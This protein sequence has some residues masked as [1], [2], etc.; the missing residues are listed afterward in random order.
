M[1]LI[2]IEFLLILCGLIPPNFFDLLFYIMYALLFVTSILGLGIFTAYTHGQSFGY[3]YTNLKLV[4]KNKRDVSGLFLILRQ[5]IGFGIPLMVIGYFFQVIGMIVW[6][7]I[8][9][10]C[11][12]ATPRQQTIA[13][14]LFKTM[15]VHEPPMSEKL[16]E[17]T[18]EFIDEPIK[19]VKQQPEPSPAISSDLVSPIDLHLRSNYSDDGYY[20][21]E[22]LFKQAY[23][24]HMEV[25]SIT[26]HNCARANAA[27]VRFAPMY[28]IQYIPGVEIDTQWKG[29][30]VRILGYYIDWT[31]DI[32]DE[33]E[34]ESL[35]REK[36]VSIERTQ[37]FEDF[38]GIHIDV[39]S[40]MQTSRFQTITAQ[41]ITKMVF[42]NK[43]VRE[44]SFVKKYLESSKNE[45]QARRRFARDVF[46][47]GGP[48]YV[49]ASYPALGDMV[50][51]IHDAGGIAILSSC[52]MDHIHD[53]EIEMLDLVT[54]HFEKVIVILNVGNIID[55]SWVKHYGDKIGAVMYVWQGGMESGNAVADL[56]CGNVNP[57]GRLTDT[58]ARNY[59]DYPSSAQFGNKKTNEYTE[60]IFVGYRYF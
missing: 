60:D 7:A 46:G 38:C 47:K 50:K 43:R 12:C 15:P 9:A 2:L 5:A 27:A 8:N 1:I 6:W 58:I 55:M 39:E 40:L 41:D 37:K 54:A 45:T 42:H 17:E 48:C 59:Y 3:V 34:R 23:Q 28:N 18:E 13:D 33:I 51:A 57:S 25:I 19:V 30:R 44:L 10:V 14:L 31:K 24:L 4:D 53:E 32:F 20:D 22:D 16:E 35:M 52:N 29:H 36:Q 49:T 21:V 26:D 11:V 56:L